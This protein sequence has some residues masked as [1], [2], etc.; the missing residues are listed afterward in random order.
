MEGLTPFELQVLWVTLAVSVVAIGYSSIM[1]AKTLRQPKGTDEMQAVWQGIHQAIEHSFGQ[2]RNALLVTTIGVAAILAASTQILPPASSA[3]ERFGDQATTWVAAG[4]A[5]GAVIGIMLSYVIGLM[6]GRLA[7]ESGVRVA[8]AGQKGYNPAMRTA[9]RSSSALSM[10]PLGV[11]LL[12]S[13]LVVVMTVIGAPDLLFGFGVGGAMGALFLQ[14]RSGLYADGAH[15]SMLQLHQQESGK[16]D[17]RH[18]ATV[19][20]L[21]GDNIGDCAGMTTALFRNGELLTFAAVTIGVLLGDFG[22]GALF[23]GQYEMRFVLLPL[24]VRAV[25]LVGGLVGNSLVRTDEK[26]RNAIAAMT[27]GFYITVV[28]C[29]VGFAAATVLL[30]GYPDLANIDWRPFYA[31]SVGVA[32]AVILERGTRMFA[33]AFFNPYKKKGDSDGRLR[34]MFAGLVKGADVNLWGI[35]TVFGA[36]VPIVVIFGYIGYQPIES[37][38]LALLYGLVLAGLGMF[39]LAANTLSINSFG[40]I[41]HTAHHLSEVAGM[42]KNT[43]NAMEDLFIVGKMMKGI[44]RGVAIGSAVITSGALLGAYVAMAGGVQLEAVARGATVD[45]LIPEPSLAEPSLINPFLISMLTGGVIGGMVIIGAFLLLNRAVAKVSEVVSQESQQHELPPLPEPPAQSEKTTKKKKDEEK[46]PVVIVDYTSVIHPANAATHPPLAI[47]ASV[48]AVVTAVVGVV[49]GA[50][51]LIG[52][53][54]GA[55]VVSQVIGLTYRQQETLLDPTG[56]QVAKPT[57]ISLVMVMA[58]ASLLVAAMSL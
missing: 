9:Y 7:S 19:A 42:D 17:P 10:A 26:R 50:Q 48:I 49:L 44:S 31:L 12:V 41:A 4:R 21:V 24:L 57:L 45:L 36:V 52:M 13:S 47:L 8:A 1:G 33:P 27:K 23:D 14:F 46:K 35:V 6:S 16:L 39:S 37:F 18:A 34:A 56:R 2:Q 54:I 32:L 3:V 28:V 58:L 29:L 30:F 43:R 51:V 5:G 11:G 38:L 40:A 25:G 22:D 55:V 15:Q 20:D 53:M